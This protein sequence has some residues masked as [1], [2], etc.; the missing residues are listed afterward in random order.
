MTVTAVLHGGCAAI[1]AM[2]A[3]LILFRSKLS[4]TGVA[5]AAATAVT[6]AWSLATALSATLSLGGP[7]VGIPGALDLLRSAAW[8]AFILQMYRQSVP[9][10]GAL[11]QA[12]VVTGTVVGLVIAASLLLGT[13]AG[14]VSL[15]STGTSVRIGLAV[16]NLLLIENVY[17]NASDEV[18]WHVN[19]PCVAL[20]GL[21]VYDIALSADAVLFRQLSMPLFDGRAVA[22]AIVAPLLA[23]AAARNRTWSID[24]HV[25]RAAAFHSATLIGSGIFLL[26]L[27]LAGQTFHYLGPGW[28]GVAEISLMFGGLMVV[29][30]VV[31]SRAAR[32]HIRRLVVDNFFSRRF[33]YHREWMRC[34]AILSATGDPGGARVYV[35]LHARV[36][37]AVAEIVDAPGGMLFLRENL[38][39]GGY[40]W[41]GSWNMPATFAVLAPDSALVAALRGGH[42]TLV[43][44]DADGLR[45]ALPPELMGAWLVVPLRHNAVMIGFIVAAPPRAAFRLDREVFDL[46]RVIGL[47]VAITVAEQRATEVL[48]QARELHEYSKRF[49]FVAHDIK[50][51]S[52]QLSLLL[53]NAETHLA[54]PEFQRD[55]LATVR[56]SVAKISALLRR[57]QGPAMPAAPAVIRPV[58][59]LEALA[60]SI[61]RLRGQAVGMELDGRGGAVAMQAAAFDA[62]VTHLLTNAFEA[63]AERAAEP[64][65]DQQDRHNEQPAPVHVHARH[66]GRRLLI[67]IVDHGSGMTPEFIRDQLFRPFGTSKIGGSGI[68]AFQARELLRE[69]GGDLLVTS[70]PGRGTTMRLLLPLV[71]AA[72]GT[73]LTTSS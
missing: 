50:N 49:A 47:Q 31:T 48:M 46:L 69:V 27:A 60:A 18:K 66:Q 4:R 7:F 42:W 16:C 11:S 23:V 57:L 12:F 2:L 36:I 56:A 14:P 33:D 37:R 24:I 54:N 68:G 40:R 38:G 5:L 55:M 65:S 34:I 64:G 39:E 63:T 9:G 26:G 13:G 58:D 15:W 67:D 20:G 22:T 51:V 28:G 62:A 6:A 1:Y 53:S 32:G 25:S 19:L 70:A 29:A 61:G 30:V 21:F 44:S 45:A 35:P 10:R 3:A 71:E 72:V 52:S 8:Y 41:A 73:L 59:R 43:L 17:R